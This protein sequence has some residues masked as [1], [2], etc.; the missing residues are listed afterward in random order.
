MTTIQYHLQHFFDNEQ[1]EVYLNEKT[2]EGWTLHS[3]QPTTTQGLEGAPTHSIFLMFYRQVG[4][5]P[6]GDEEVAG[7]IAMTG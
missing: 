2:Q 3:W 5:E 7:A 1:A 6:G 4:E